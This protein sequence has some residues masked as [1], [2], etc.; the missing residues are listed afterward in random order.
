MLAQLVRHEVHLRQGK[1]PL[2]SANEAVADLRPVKVAVSPLSYG[3]VSDKLFSSSILRSLV[4]ARL[5]LVEA[6]PAKQRII[7][8]FNKRVEGVI[9]NMALVAP[10]KDGLAELF[11]YLIDVFWLDL[12]QLLYII[13]RSNMV[14]NAF[15][16]L[17]HV[18]FSSRDF[19]TEV[20]HADRGGLTRGKW[21][22]AS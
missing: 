22:P 10:K 9:A 7:D 11:P 15:Q 1:T 18:T 20:A 19:W 16:P 8:A 3:P 5:V 14:W 12:G 6:D 2:A 4:G 17:K 21:R 13:D